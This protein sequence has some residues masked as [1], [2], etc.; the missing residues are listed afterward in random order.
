MGEKVIRLLIALTVGVL[1]TRYLGP[2]EFGILSYAQSFVG[3]FAAFS[4]LGLSDILVRE[5]VK[6]KKESNVLLGT[7]FWLQTVGSIIIMICLLL[8]INF[9]DN[10]PLTNKIIL[11]LGFITFLQ[12]FGV[13]TNY[14]NSLVKSK[15]SAIPGLIGIFISATAKLILIWQKAPLLYFVYVLTFDVLFLVFGQ[16]YFYYKSGNS[17]FNWEFSFSTAKDLLKDSWPL[18]LSSIVI[19][20]YMKV[21][22][23]MIKEILDN[24]SVGQYSAA[25]RLSEAWYFIPTIICSSLFPAI[26]NAK[27]KSN[28]LYISRLQ[29]LFDLMVILGLAI[30]FPV[31][32]FGDWAI[33]FLYGEEFNKTASVLKIHIWAGVFVFLGVANQ[34]W[35]ISENLQAYNILCLGLGMVANIVLNIIFIPIYGIYGAAFATLVSQ[36]IASV[37]APV[38]FKKTRSSF[39]MMMK[40]LF[41]INTFKK[42]LKKNVLG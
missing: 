10:K 34:K 9:N 26:I 14:F 27:I 25:V 35:F 1:V 30:V 42:L 18:I 13:I 17:I 12:S 37:I 32:I 4:S 11:I 7:S 24:A 29:R 21:D 36:F 23:I 40:S 3:L 15:F 16:L 2:E 31:L 8:F 22:Q 19:S 6:S 20:I 39:F 5:L 33:L 38:G 41:L 28:S